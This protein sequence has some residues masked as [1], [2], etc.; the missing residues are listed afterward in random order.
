[1]AMDNKEALTNFSKKI[2]NHEV[3]PKSTDDVVIDG[4]VNTTP[5]E[6]AKDEELD[7]MLDD[8]VIVGMNKEDV[9]KADTLSEGNEE[10]TITERWQKMIREQMADMA[11]RNPDEFNS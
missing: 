6:P 10:T 3:D 5:E 7:D 8:A 1:M 4:K 2:E 11:N 9:A